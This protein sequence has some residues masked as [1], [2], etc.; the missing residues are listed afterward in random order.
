M[1]RPESVS[2]EPVWQLIARHE[3]QNGT[4][5]L[6]EGEHTVGSSAACD[7]RMAHPT[8]SRR[9]A[10][11]R[12]TADSVS[13]ED[14]GSTNG[15][16]VDG[17]AIAGSGS[18]GV[19]PGSE[20]VFGQLSFVLARAASRPQR[21]RL[22]T[23]DLLGKSTIGEL[24]QDAD[25]VVYAADEI[26]VRRGERSQWLYVI[27]SGEV[28]LSLH[29]DGT[30]RR[31]LAR[32][33]P[34]AT[35]G[36]ESVLSEQASAVDAIALETVHVLR[37]PITALATALDRS[38]SLRGK[39]LRGMA[40]QFRE[41][42][43]DVLDL[44]RGTEVISRL[45]Q[46]DD[47]P[48]ELVAVSARM[49]AVTKRMERAAGSRQPVLLVGENGTG[50]TLAAHQ[51]HQTS[52][53]AQGPL[54]A[55]SCGK[56]AP[57]H[58]TELILGPTHD[59]T[60]GS[61]QGGGID[62]ARGGTLLLEDV[63]LL[64]TTDQLSLASSLGDDSSAAS[65]RLPATRIVASAGATSDGDGT[66]S[67]IEAS[68]LEQ[69]EHVI[70]LP[71]L[72]DRR[73]D[74]VPLAEQFLEQSSGEGSTLSESARHALL[75]M[76]Y[77]RA[78][79]SELRE[80]IELAARVADGPEIRAE[81]ILS[82]L[83]DDAPRGLDV[84]GSTP[85]AILTRDRWLT[86]LKAA[87]AAGFLGVI[88]LCLLAGTTAIGQIANA[89]I[90]TTWEPVVFASFLLIGPLWCT[91]CPLSASSRWAQRM[92]CLGR[93]PPEW[94][95]R[96]GPW[97]AVAGFA[98]IV[99]SE[100]MF[101]MT[102]R[103]FGSGVLLSALLVAAMVCGVVYSREVWCRHL[104][105]LGRLAV[106][107]A[108]A[109]PL[110]LGASRSVCAST[111][112]GHE[113]YR[114][115]DAVPG[116][117]VYHHPLEGRESHRC[118]LCLDCL[119]SCPHGSARLRL[120]WPLRGLWSVDTNATDLALFSLTVTVLAALLLLPVAEAGTHQPLLFTALCVA[121][122][123]FGIGAHWV[124]LGGTR[125]STPRATT[126]TRVIVAVMVLGWSALMASQLANVSVLR[127]LHIVTQP[128]TA[129][130]PSQLPLLTV[131]QLLVLVAAWAATTF[132]LRTIRRTAPP[133][134]QLGPIAWWSAHGLTIA[135]TVTVAA[136]VLG[137]P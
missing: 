40:H 49:R 94:M 100:R 92:K 19:I 101:A 1:Q 116:C 96:H 35:F 47:E 15:T 120:S 77:R 115:N 56:L 60:E 38:A 20:L 130:L 98:V 83:E 112:S 135:Y 67:R 52:A 84:T 126:I 31:P 28:E 111:C 53:Y 24:R 103:P 54:I 105:P 88:G 2:R 16:F 110:E 10:T 66:A 114:G 89:G 42:T 134:G 3:G 51:I 74:I 81:H 23:P 39:L 62:L 4:V 13:V 43:C 36:A 90:W 7:I 128:E 95:R 30:H 12:C 55:V 8:V 9:H 22:D 106:T 41:V 29:D 121:T 33:G 73:R 45:V 80:I 107:V 85:V 26:I 48:S 131:A 61:R 58:A 117:T 127:E 124:L 69:F 75:A 123:V 137:R 99:W 129:W 78:N 102:T 50:R 79:V 27:I 122:V 93:P 119:R 109:A 14:L 59:G 125:G 82:G 91:I 44:L 136:L 57:E 76:G 68:L 87:T 46:G 5:S 132:A 133:D 6:T 64:D 71:T 17:H 25:E 18:V 108:P 97:L 113:C 21:R 11:I 65:G 37:Y 70:H 72:A 34:G 32:L 63:D 104:C 86:G 118:K